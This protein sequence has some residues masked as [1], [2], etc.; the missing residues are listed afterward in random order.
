MQDN[1]DRDVKWIAFPKGEAKL[2]PMD[3]PGY[4]PGLIL[5]FKDT[6]EGQAVMKKA[7]TL[8]FRRSTMKSG[9]LCGVILKGENGYGFGIS[10]LA[11]VLDAEVIKI[12][13]SELLAQKFPRS[14]PAAEKTAEAP[15]PEAPKKAKT[16]IERIVAADVAVG[17]EIA[18]LLKEVDLTP[19]APFIEEPESAPALI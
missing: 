1:S 9:G 17:D 5:I 16:M 13:T 15:A 14:A 12:K 4:G 8:N 10:Q 6:P 2:F 19:D 7:E 18:A 11:K 3:L